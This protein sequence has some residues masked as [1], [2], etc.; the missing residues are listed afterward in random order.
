MKI[1]EGWPTR[2]MIEAAWAAMYSTEGN[3]HLDTWDQL[4]LG[5]KA[6][7]A[8]APTPPAQE[9]EPV[10]QSSWDEVYW[11]DISKTEFDARRGIT[12]IHNRT[13]YTRP[14]NSELRKAAEELLK[15]CDGKGRHEMFHKTL[16]NLRAAL[17]GK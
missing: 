15:I 6:A 16:E 1:P 3:V 14:D 2:V 7:L 11:A 9:D 17:E 4:E 8:A 13:L 12:N 10:Y 5:V